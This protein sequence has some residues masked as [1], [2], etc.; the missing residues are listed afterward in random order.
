MKKFR[1][2]TLIFI[3]I[4][5]VGY[6]FIVFILPFQIS[7]LPSS[8]IYLDQG[9]QEIGEVIYSGSIRHRGMTFEKIPEFS[10]RSLIALE[11]RTFYDNNGVSL[12]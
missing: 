4:I 1:L 6:F 12:R 2:F 7:P 8:T 10:L 11:D 9:G 5:A 3:V